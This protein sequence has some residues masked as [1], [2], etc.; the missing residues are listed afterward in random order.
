MVSHN[1][2]NINQNTTSKNSASKEL[3][4][5]LKNSPLKAREIFKSKIANNPRYQV[6]DAEFLEVV[7]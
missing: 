5:L 3:E 1:C 4:L 7:F 2:K 6:S